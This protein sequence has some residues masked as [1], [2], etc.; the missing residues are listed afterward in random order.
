MNRRRA[1]QCLAAVVSLSLAAGAVAHQGKEAVTRVL[2]NPRTGNIEVMHRFLIHD[3]EHAVREIF[4][5][6]ADLLGSESSRAQFAEYV[7]QRFRLADQDGQSLALSS[8]GHEID[9]K[10]LWIYAETPSPAHLTALNVTHNALRDLWPAQ[11]NLVTV[12]RG[13]ENRSALFAGGTNSV[14]LVL[15]ND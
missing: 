8:V 11:S 15:A 1:L 12:E 3:A 10:Y 4:G 2:F 9:G 14:T 6:D 13:D 5:A 7:G